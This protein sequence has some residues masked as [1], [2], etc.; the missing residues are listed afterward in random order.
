MTEKLYVNCEHCGK[1][2]PSPIQMDKTSFATATLTQN[3]YQ[4]PH[5]DKTAAYD[6]PDHFFR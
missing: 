4:C 6:G 2:F 1:A 5:C 3:S